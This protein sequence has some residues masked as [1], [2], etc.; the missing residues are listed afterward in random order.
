MDGMACPAGAV[1]P[2]RVRH[3]AEELHV[4]GRAEIVGRVVADGHGQR[5]RPHPLQPDREGHRLQPEA[6]ADPREVLL[7]ALRHH[8]HVRAIG[9]DGGEGEVDVEAARMAGLCHQRL[10]A[11]EIAW[12]RGQVRRAREAVRDRRRLALPGAAEHEFEHRPIVDGQRDRLPHLR[13]QPAGGGGRAGRHRQVDEVRRGQ[14]LHLGPALRQGAR[15]LGIELHGDVGAARGQQL[16]LYRRVAA[17]ADHHL[18]E[19]R[20]IAPI[21]GVPAEAEFVVRPVARQ[22]EGAAAGGVLGEPAVAA[23]IRDGLAVARMPAASAAWR[24]TTPM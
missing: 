11:G 3:H 16:A 6:D 24:S 12:R 5:A 9:V 17:L 19:G 18:G 2:G 20:R 8:R 23:I 21:G 15:R 7:Q 14:H 4:L 10:G 22:D 1:E 13:R